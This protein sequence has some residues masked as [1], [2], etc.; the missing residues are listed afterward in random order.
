[1]NT[2]LKVKK[3]GNSQGIRIPK[4]FLKVLGVDTNDEVELSINENEDSLILKKTTNQK[5]TMKKLF[6]GYE[7]NYN[8]EEIDWGERQGK[9]EW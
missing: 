1:M 4:N 7:G 9:E 6:E 8:A 5:V 2:I 3:W